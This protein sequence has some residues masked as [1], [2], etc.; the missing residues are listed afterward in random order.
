MTSAPIDWLC[1]K[2]VQIPY[3]WIYYVSFCKKKQSHVITLPNKL[4]YFNLSV[5]DASTFI[6]GLGPPQAPLRFM[7]NQT[8]NP[9]QLYQFFAGPT[10]SKVK[11]WGP[12]FRSR[13]SRECSVAKEINLPW[14][15]RRDVQYPSNEPIWPMMRVCAMKKL[16]PISSS[17]LKGLAPK[18]CHRGHHTWVI[19]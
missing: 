18:L 14:T 4:S 1:S 15:G 17:R 10:L 13:C 9:A 16:I 5:I 3:S 6:H 8:L 12:F 7:C 11:W 19:F 2:F